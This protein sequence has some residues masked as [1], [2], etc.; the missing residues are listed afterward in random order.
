MSAMNIKVRVDD[1][2]TRRMTEVAEGLKAAGMSINQQ[3]DALGMIMGSYESSQLDAL[4]QVPGVAN[5][6]AQKDYQIAP[7]NAGIQ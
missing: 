4:R 7:P 3:L 5:V 1:Q 2:H 6:S